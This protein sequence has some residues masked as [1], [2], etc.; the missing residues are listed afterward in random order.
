[1]TT[2]QYK[3]RTLRHPNL[4]DTHHFALSQREDDCRFELEQYV[5]KQYLATHQARLT[6]FLPHLLSMS[7][8]GE[9]QAVAGLKPA[10]SGQLFLEQYLDQNIDQT[11]AGAINR[12]IDRNSIIEI[13]NLASS[14]TGGSQLLFIILAFAIREAGF[15]WLAFT[16]TP[17]VK[18]LLNRLSATPL[19]LANAD[20]GRLGKTAEVWGEYYQKKPNVMAI[21]LD[22]ALSN[23]SENETIN[24]VSTLYEADIK[25]IAEQ[26]KD[27]SEQGL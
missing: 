20:A 27:H 24:Y 3:K 25:N 22:E 26:L 17:Q 19:F 7:L 4:A 23:V 13:G 10:S 5:A 21:D 16:A 11:I 2:H 1:M 14:Q 6:S 15:H 8:S 12:P 9:I 18:K